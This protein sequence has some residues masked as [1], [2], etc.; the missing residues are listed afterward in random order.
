MHKV[1]IIT[2]YYAYKVWAARLETTNNKQ[3]NSTINY[4]NY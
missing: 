3:A 1:L 2:L 4:Y